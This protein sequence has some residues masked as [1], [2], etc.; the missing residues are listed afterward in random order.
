[1]TLFGTL[2]GT[3]ITSNL[4]QQKYLGWLPV[5]KLLR[6]AKTNIYLAEQERIVV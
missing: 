6:F 2:L 4:G 5:V 3:L 1:M